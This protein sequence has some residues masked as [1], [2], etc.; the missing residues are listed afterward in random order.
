MIENISAVIITKNACKTMTNTLES[1]RDFKEVI[2]FDSGSIDGTLEIIKN[3]PNVE[4]HQGDFH[5]FGAAKNHAINLASN[6]WIFSL[7]ADEILSKDLSIHLNEIDLES[8]LIGEVQ[9]KNFFMGKEITT[10]G[11]GRD[12]IIR[13]F[14]RKEFCF[15]DLKVHEKVEIDSSAKKVLLNGS[16]IHLAINDLSETLEKANLYSELY[17]K[18]NNTL[19][20]IFIILFKAK[21]AFI[22]TYFF[23][24]GFLAGWRGFILSVANSIG[25]FY[26]YIKIYVEHKQNIKK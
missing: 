13:L 5:G 14:N 7:D 16:L 15:S 12:M 4:L 11:W 17:A 8:K 2:V 21:Y 10:A 20:P 3:Y 6:D 22:R 18:E 19:Y 1:L 25:V 9:R 24:K 26:K 23:Q